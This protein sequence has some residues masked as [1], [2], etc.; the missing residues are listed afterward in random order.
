MDLDSNFSRLMASDGVQNSESVRPPTTALAK[1]PMVR[2]DFNYDGLFDLLQQADFFE[3]LGKVDQAI[4]ALEHGI[5]GNH[6][7]SPLC[8]LE[9]LRIANNHN[10][11]TDFR[12]FRIE[13]ERLFN[14]TVPE[15]ALFRDEGRKLEAY[16]ALTD[17]ICKLWPTSSVLD[18]IEACV[19]RDPMEKNAEPFDMAAFKDLILLHGIARSY[20]VANTGSGTVHSYIDTQ[21]VDI[22]M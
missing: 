13:T 14:V 6:K 5:Q 7:N 1:E 3:K 19:V 4:E 22:D 18:V 12:Q 2:P 9:L 15:F 8:Y 20:E 16:P 10:L 17:H 21:H 11:K